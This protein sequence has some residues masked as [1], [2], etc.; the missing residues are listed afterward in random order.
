MTALRVILASQSPRR[1]ELLALVGI[2][3][4]VQPADI[5]ESYLTGERPR[6][7]AE[8]LA[9]GKA[10]VI[11]GREPGTETG[12]KVTVAGRLSDDPDWS[13]LTSDEP[14]TWTDNYASVLSVLK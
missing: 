2:A 3:H 11:A 4:D 13:P 10:E 7:H 9:R 14:V 12:T 5:D 6:D 1:R 8:R